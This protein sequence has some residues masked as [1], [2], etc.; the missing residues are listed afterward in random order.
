[1]GFHHSPQIVTNGLV[2]CLDAG[3]V[4]SY[5]GSGTTWTD[6]SGNGGVA[7][8]TGAPTFSNGVFTFNGTTQYAAAGTLSGVA[9]ICTVSAFV[10]KGTTPGWYGSLFGFGTSTE[11]TQDLYYWSAQH[12]MGFNT[13]NT[14]CYG[15]A[16]AD[17]A[18]EAMDGNW[19]HVGVVFNRTAITSGKI[20]VDGVLKTLS[21][22]YGTTLT[23]TV[24]SNFGVGYNGHWSGT[25]T[26]GGSL[27]SIQVYNRELSQAE[28]TQ[29]YRAGKKRFGL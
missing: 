2:L 4:K 15:Y 25:Q 22:T 23:R 9:T 7:T 21:Q 17:A 16:N 11:T 1:M 13:W 12:T 19:H 20:Y 6:I 10:K 28:I 27:Q 18:G 3:N 5:P 8:I 29:N 26:Y 14:D 24:S